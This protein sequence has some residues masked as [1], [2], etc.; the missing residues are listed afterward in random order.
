MS[1][2]ELS[3]AGEEAGPEVAKRSPLLRALE[4]LGTVVAVIVVI[5][6]INL[7]SIPAGLTLGQLVVAFVAVSV[8][9]EGMRWVRRGARK[10]ARRRFARAIG[11]YGGGLYGTAALAT[12]VWLNVTDVLDD[13]A[14]AG[15]VAAY[16]GDM[17][18][19]WLIG[20]AVEAVT[21]AIQSMIWPWHWFAEYGPLVPLVILGGVLAADAVRKPV[22][23]WATAR[24]GA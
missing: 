9:V 3:V 23:R 22:A 20:E 18:L 8:A 14:A 5:L 16:I 13:I 6:I 17:S 15:S 10:E 7:G 21:F 2:D 24:R 1:N 19:G 12:F 4:T 11:E